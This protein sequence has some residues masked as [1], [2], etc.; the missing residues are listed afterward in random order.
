V[1]TQGSIYL[2]YGGGAPASWSLGGPGLAGREGRRRQITNLRSQG[3]CDGVR[4]DDGG[5]TGGVE[6]EGGVG[7]G[8]GMMARRRGRRQRHRGRQRRWRGIEGGG[9]TEGGKLGQP[10]GANENLP[11]LGFHVG[12]VTPLIPDTLLVTADIVQSIPKM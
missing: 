11:R 9:G 12:R 4:D 10:D 8:V 6:A 5:T 7:N 2:T 3:W 1:I